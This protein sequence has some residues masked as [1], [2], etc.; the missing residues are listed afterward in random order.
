MSIPSEKQIAL[1]ITTRFF[2]NKHLIV[3]PNCGW[4]GH[5]C[6]LLCVTNNLKLIDFEIKRTKADFIADAKKAKWHGRL[7][8]NKAWKHYYL[9]PSSIYEDSFIELMPSPKC[10][11]LTFGLGRYSNGNE[12]VFVNCR[13]KADRN[14]TFTDLTSAQVL[15]V[16]RLAGLR[17]WATVNKEAV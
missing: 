15:D 5:E 7:W 4:T 6:D 1:A 16:A 8:P 13:K 14:P 17:Y 12:Y 3:V 10:G 2:N 9:I 11:I